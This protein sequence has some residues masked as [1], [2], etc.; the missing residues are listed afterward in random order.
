M[1]KLK[2]RNLIAAGLRLNFLQS[3]WNFERLQ[4]AGFLFAV[5]PLLKIIYKESPEALRNAVKRHFNFF[6]TNFFFSSAALGVMAKLEEELPNDEPARK[7]SEIENTKLG[8]MG[9]LAAIGD[10]LFWSGLKPFALLCGSAIVLLNGFELKSIIAAAAV[11]LAVF[12]LP[13][14]IIKYYLLVKSYYNHRELFILI[15]KVKFQDIMKSI[16]IIGIGLAGAV[17]ASYMA[18][19]ELTLV[20]SR[21][22]DSILLA[23]AYFL[24]SFALKK[25]RT[26][27]QVFFGT[28]LICIVFSYIH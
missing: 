23:A 22:M 11:S 10:S 14:F 13:K 8:I 5:Y 24:M 3:S 9:P 28:V 16:K 6:N 26:V 25:K 15:Q 7:D 21:L 18:V 4:N 20:Q 17:M 27:S 12:N 19:K 2:A 1:N